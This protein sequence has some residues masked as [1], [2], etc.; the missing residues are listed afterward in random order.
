MGNLQTVADKS[1]IAV[2]LLC[3]LHCVL[4]P[5]AV[6]LY[7][8]TLGSLAED[9]T[10]HL[11]LLF[12]VIPISTIALLKGGKIHKSRKVPIIGFTGLLVLITAVILGHDVL[13]DLGEKLLTV[14][15]SIIVVIAHIQNHLICQRTN[16]ANCHNEDI[17]CPAAKD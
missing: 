14:L 1:A 4:L 15:G 3:A 9:E 2:S 17:V 16:C 5:A 10:V 12:L 6:I 8:T 7:P 13:G 11:F